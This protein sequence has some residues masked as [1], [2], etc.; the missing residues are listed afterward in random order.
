MDK[1]N[2]IAL[3]TR[4]MQP[5]IHIHLAG[6]RL[7][8]TRQH[9]DDGGFSGPILAQQSENFTAR[10][11]K[12]DIIDGKRSAKR[13]H[14]AAQGKRSILGNAMRS[15]FSEVCSRHSIPLG[16]LDE[17][18]FLISKARLA[19]PHRP[20]N[21]AFIGGCTPVFSIHSICFGFRAEASSRPPE[22]PISDFQ[23][24]EVLR[25]G[26]HAARR[27]NGARINALEC[28]QRLKLR[29]TAGQFPGE[30]MNF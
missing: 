26:W 8:N 28:Y 29:Q 16:A 17:R 27:L 12:T 18:I 21:R 14:H 7:V 3:G 5:A 13:L 20:V 11:V 10:K 2:R 24:F 15:R 4:I 1:G 30:Q 9:F 19:T 22:K 25:G 6:I 23:G